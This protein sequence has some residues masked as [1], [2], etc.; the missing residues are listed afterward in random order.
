MFSCFGK[1]KKEDWRNYACHICGEEYTSKTALKI[2][3]SAHRNSRIPRKSYKCNYPKC[4][5]A[6]DTF[7]Q[8]HQHSN[9]HARRNFD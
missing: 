1:K 3:E 8:L 5:Q 4:K 2:H 9:V 7:Q 6:F